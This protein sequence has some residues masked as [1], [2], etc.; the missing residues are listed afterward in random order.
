MQCDSTSKLPACVSR[1]RDG[2]KVSVLAAAL[3]I[4][5]GCA[6][7]RPADYPS[8]EAAAD[9][10][11]VALRSDDPALL[12]KVLGSD[13]ADLIS[14]GDDVS[15]RNSIEKFLHA[16][17][18]RHQLTQTSADSVTIEVG[19]DGWPLP[20]PIVRDSDSDKWWFDAEAGR[21]EVL[22]RRIGRNE[23]DVIQVCHAII[24]AQR[25]YAALDPNGDGV[26]EYAAKFISDA[27]NRNGLY[28][29]TKEG[30]PPSP[31]GA[32]VA[33]AVEEGYGGTRN[34]P[35][36]RTPYHGYCYHM[37]TAQGPHAEGGAL[38]YR[39]QGR[40]IGGFAA[41]A[42][43]AEYGD[44]GI[45][46]FIVNHRGVVYQK[47]LGED[48]GRLARAMTTFDPGEGW[49]AVESPADV[50]AAPAEPAK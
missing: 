36:D 33:S 46:T 44:S 21:D 47:D 24:D 5:Q 4:A 42:Y 3:F 31:L 7:S 10:L 34:A 27:G 17:D 38:D 8:P 28:F 6:A 14:S 49:K 48:T 26:A 2:L 23:L 30:E 35:P 25:D 11:V 12:K 29:P 16:Y 22:N 20:I 50:A 41:V 18:E 32:L 1:F 40:M 19:K 15:D 13:S 39:I 9:A 43:P 37:L 45:M